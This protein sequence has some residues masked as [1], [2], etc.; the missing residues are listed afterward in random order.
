MRRPL[1][2]LGWLAVTGAAAAQVPDTVRTD[3]VDLRPLTVTATREPKDPFLVP[4]A[5]SAV[6]RRDFRGTRGFGL[7]DALALVP[8]VVAASRYGTSDV[9]IIIRGFGAR[10]AGDRSNAGTSRGIRVLVDGFPETEPDGRTSF[11]LVELG[12]A[13]SLE[14]VRSNASAVWGNAAGGVIAVS[15]VPAFERWLVEAAVESGAFGLRR[16]RAG[17][18]T[19]LGTGRLAAFVTHTAFD[20]W[21]DHSGAR[22]SVLNLSV[23]APLADRTSIGVFATASDNVFRIPGPLTRA[24]VAADPRQ[25]NATYAARDERRENRIARLGL[26]LAHAPG[27]ASEVRATLFVAPK[28]LQRSERGTFRDFTRYH[29]GGSVTYQT[30]VTIGPGARATVQGGADIAYQDGAILFYSL[31]PEGTR[32]DTLRTDK[33]E[34]AG[35]TGAFL[36]ADIAVGPRLVIS[37]GARYDDIAYDYEDHLDPRRDDARAFSGVTPKA[38][39][40]W[41][42]GRR[43]MVYGAV[44]GGI[45]APAGNETDPAGTFGEDTVYGINPLLDP[46]RSATFEIGTRQ[47]V[48]AA[49]GPL[50]EIAYDVALYT[51]VVENEIVPYQGG[52]FY[53]TAG[54]ARRRGAEAAVRIAAAGGLAIQGSLA[55]SDHRY[56]DYVVDSVHYGVPG[57]VA[58]YSGNRVVGVPDLTWAA[59]VGIAPAAVA[60]IA[61]R[62]TLQG[63][64]AYYA[65][66]ANTISIPGYALIAVSVRTERPLALGRSWGLGGFVTVN[67]AADRSYVGSAFLNPESLNGEP[68]AFEPGLPR[69]VTVGVSIGAGY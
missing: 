34:G 37:A 60:P 4:L 18:G 24:E 23:T 32:G 41:R 17:G 42:L 29:V 64:S 46:I 52:R 5:T 33:R 45:E 15:T 8:G 62:V 7:D 48:R 51:T 16:A 25:A 63:Q 55:W 28:F 10:G 13:Q 58:D 54:R 38:G 49:R 65:D 36:Q 14:V 44:G 2:A 21:R 39:I 27:L 67:N 68:V 56:T 66:D 61:A 30:A 31:A 22:R 9:R 43:H 26:A 20:G 47:A 11:D 50:D 59:S 53:F 12:A 69:N 1:L 19:L 3:T 57:A 40:T 6:T 35:N